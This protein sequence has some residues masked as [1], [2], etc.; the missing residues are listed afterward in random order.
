MI[1]SLRQKNLDKITQDEMKQNTGSLQ[2]IFDKV[3]ELNRRNNLLKAK[4]VPLVV[5][6]CRG[7]PRG[8]P[9]LGGGYDKGGRKARPY[10]TMI[11]FIVG[12]P[13]RIPNVRLD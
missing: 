13:L 4:R 8:C 6:I 7:T 10:K 3:T 2:Q 5:K 12:Y 11:R 1:L 9:P